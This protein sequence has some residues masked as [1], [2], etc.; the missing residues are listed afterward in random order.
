VGVLHLDWIVDPEA[1][2]LGISNQLP[3]LIQI[4]QSEYNATQLCTQLLHYD[5]YHPDHFMHR[6]PCDTCT[7]AIDTAFWQPQWATSTG[8]A[9]MNGI[10][11]SGTGICSLRVVGM[12]G[13][14]AF[15]AAVVFSIF[16]S[17]V[18]DIINYNQ[19]HHQQAKRNRPILTTT[20]TPLLDHEETIPG[21]HYQLMDGDGHCAEEKED[22][23]EIFPLLSEDPIR[24][25]L[26]LEPSTNHH[27]PFDASHNSSHI[28]TISSN[29]FILVMGIVQCLFS[30]LALNLVAMAIR[31]KMLRRHVH[32]AIPNLL[33]DILSM[34]WE[35]S[36]SLLD[37]RSMTGA[38]GGW[39]Q[40]LLEN[41]FGLFLIVGPWLLAMTFLICY[42][43]TTLTTLIKAATAT[44]TTTTTTSVIVETQSYSKSSSSGSLFRLIISMV[45]SFCAWEVWMLAI[46][47]IAMLMP[48]IT[49]TILMDPQCQLLDP[50]TGSCFLVDF[51]ILA[52][53][54]YLIVAGVVLLSMMMWM[55]NS[56]IL[57]SHEG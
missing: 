40:W 55:T 25:N 22:T 57:G 51:E 6:I 43:L 54:R 30:W 45:A 8:R 47:M 41:T 9:I 19:E 44:A 16:L 39:D 32:G 31:T 7:T 49:N 14:Y 4:I 50:T 17:V 46:V 15:C 1:I 48:S 20:T 18:V 28:R 13:M 27:T 5:C 34:E 21:I 29:C 38:A 10:D 12:K 23:D 35:E 53:F 33:H 11:A 24:S 52:E 36:Y 37:L 56:R 2:R 26:E 42:F 3:Q